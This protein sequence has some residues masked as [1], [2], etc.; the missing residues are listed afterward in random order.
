MRV[1]TLLLTLVVLNDVDYSEQ[2][3]NN[4]SILVPPSEDQLWKETY[5]QFIRNTLK[6]NLIYTILFHGRNSTLELMNPLVQENP[7]RMVVINYDTID[8]I[9]ML[10][11]IRHL[12]VVIM[13]SPSDFL[14][15]LEVNHYKL[16]S[17][18]MILFISDKR[19]LLNRNEV[20]SIHQWIN[21]KNAGNLFIV[22]CYKS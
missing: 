8:E 2:S 21:L 20:S 15:F 1:F 5:E 4:F 3:L 19:L 17:Q 16:K 7:V 13:I 22:S 14:Q 6:Y 10:R 9:Y 11:G 18:H 12:H